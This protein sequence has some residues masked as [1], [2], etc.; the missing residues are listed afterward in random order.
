MGQFGQPCPEPTQW[1][2]RA[3]ASS[4]R[5]TAQVRELDLVRDLPTRD[6]EKNTQ[7]YSDCRGNPYLSPRTF[8][9]VMIMS[10][11]HESRR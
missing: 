4:T 1:L 11:C 6:L 5:V 10:E 3:T 7:K 8:I 9:L 2:C